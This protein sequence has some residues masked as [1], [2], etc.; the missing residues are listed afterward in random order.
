MTIREQNI[1]NTQVRIN[2]TSPEDR[3]VYSDG[4]HTFDELY[5]VKLALNAVLFNELSTQYKNNVHKS[6]RHNDGTLCFGGGWFIVV[7]ELPT[8]NISF[9]YKI[10]H[11]DLFNIPEVHKSYIPFDNH[12]TQDVVARLKAM[13]TTLKGNGLYGKTQVV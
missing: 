11:W 5:E 4:Y 10:E 7:A 8:G 2:A 13:T 12:T 3:G 6:L 1:A 9:H